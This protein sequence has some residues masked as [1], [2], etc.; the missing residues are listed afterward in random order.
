MWSN[1]TFTVLLGIALL[2][3][4]ELL[5]SPFTFSQE[6]PVPKS[7]KIIE[8]E[9]AVAGGNSD[10]VRNFWAFVEANGTPLIEPIDGDQTNSLV[11]FVWRGNGET[12]NVL[13]Q[14]PY[15]Q[16]N[17]GRRRMQQVGDTNVWYKTEKIAS[18]TRFCYRFSV[19]DPRLPIGN[20]YEWRQFTVPLL[21]DPFNSK[22]FTYVIDDD[23]P[24]DYESIESLLDLPLAPKSPFIVFDKDVK[25][26]ELTKT[27]FKSNILPDERRIWY[28]TPPG[29]TTKKKYPLVIFLDGWDY[30]N[31]IP[32]QTTLDN[33]IAAGKIEPVVA[34]FV[35]TPVTP[36]VREKE[37]YANSKFS[38]L[39]ISEI[40]PLVRSK[41]SV[42]TKPDKTTVVGLSAS[43]FAGAFLALH[44]SD[45]IGNVVMQSPALWWGTDR[46]FENG[47]WLTREYVDSKKLNIR[48]YV[49][50][51]KY[52]NQP[53]TMRGGP[54]PLY[55]VRHFSDVLKLKGYKY[56]YNEFNGAHD[57]INWRQSLPDALIK[58]LAK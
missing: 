47:E 20:P 16:W 8:L 48:F 13:V 35:A 40:L 33:L 29:Y 53:A 46:Y 37:Y 27:Q 7:G 22:H 1:K 3:V 55:A 38:D 2:M 21:N 17:M 39:M 52:E 49:E 23:L 28:Y 50:V 44:H 31:H 58:V 57:Y 19:N 42:F 15:F 36:G 25:H 30:L 14:T 4:L 26:G 10:A 51:G 12:R 18:D 24:G 43:G 11:T 34:V 56:F 9:N 41:Y 5:F 54:I 45:Q 32:A 6:L